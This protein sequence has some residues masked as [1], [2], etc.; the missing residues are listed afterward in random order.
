MVSKSARVFLSANKDRRGYVGV[1]NIIAPTPFAN[2]GNDKAYYIDRYMNEFYTLTA[3][4]IKPYF[5]VESNEFINPE[6]IE[7]LNTFPQFPPTAAM[8]YLTGI[9]KYEELEK[10]YETNRYIIFNVTGSGMRKSYNFCYDKEQRSVSSYTRMVADIFYADPIGTY[11]PYPKYRVP[12]GWYFSLPAMFVK[13][14]LMENKF[15]ENLDK[16]D[17][18]EKY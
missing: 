12:N 3:R 13:M 2:N 5:M 8:D 15:T 11:I 1:N 4:E 16:I 10:Y 7:E 6:N 14:Y 17:N 18:L 9:D